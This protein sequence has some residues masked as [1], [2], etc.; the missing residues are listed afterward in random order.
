MA[1]NQPGKEQRA[2][3]SSTARVGGLEDLIRR[4]NQRFGG[5]GGD[6]GQRPDGRVFVLLG[7]LALAVWLM[8]GFYQ[9]DPA[10]RGV[11]QR[12]G[13]FNEVTD[14]GPR[15]HLPSPIET[16]S[17]V[18]ISNVNSI[19]YQSR[20][21]TS[22]VNLVSISCAI[23]YQYAD[24]QRVLFKVRDPETTLREVSES[25][26]REVIG[27]NKLEAV[28][29]GEPRRAITTNT[30]DLIQKTLDGYGV[31]IRVVSVNLTDVQVPEQVLASQ[32]DANKAIED[33]ERF[34]KVAQGYAND[35]LPQAR[36][37][38][39]RQLLDAE[40]YKLQVVA[41]AEGDASRFSQL[42]AAYVQ[43]PEVTR[44]R[45]Y[46]ETMETVL[47]RSRKVIVDTK[48]GGNNM[49]Y[50]PLDKLMNA[51]NTSSATVTAEPLQSLTPSGATTDP[52]SRERGER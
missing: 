31:G 17:K 52:R 27:Q 11:V 20:M 4:L 19:D 37:M 49:L 50:L 40:A 3:S 25:A 47:S 35:L 13:R 21:L 41:A 30:R 5:G 42:L 1:W 46:L 48:N 43:A 10:E 33:K 44:N 39:Q 29:A 7:V 12:F 6:K 9:V 14:P 22:D 51:G 15:W 34:S 45:L 36:G 2:K 23:Q 24:P 32:R 26:I 28:L 18:N 8:T 16:V 38:A